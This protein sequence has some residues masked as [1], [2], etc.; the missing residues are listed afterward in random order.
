MSPDIIIAMD[1]GLL[2]RGIN[3]DHQFLPYRRSAEPLSGAEWAGMGQAIRERE[4]AAA[5]KCGFTHIRLCFSR[6]LLQSR[7]PPYEFHDRGFDLLFRAVSM[8]RA[9]EMAVI[10]DLHELPAPEFKKDPS[11]KD[12]FLAFWR[13]TSRRCRDLPADVFYGL[14]NEPI[15]YDPTF[16]RALAIEAIKALR[17]NDARRP[18]LVAGDAWGSLESLVAMGD[19]NLPNIIY[20]FHFYCP[21]AF[22]HQGAGWGGPRHESPP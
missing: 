11:L 8:I 1:L 16:W 9:H 13:E 7:K 12:V 6:D 17:E 5:A 4:F 10:L 2:R 21:F 20:D 3:I 19:L 22:T 15:T 18:V 14:L